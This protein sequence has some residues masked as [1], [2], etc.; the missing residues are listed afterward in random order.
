MNGSDPPATMQRQS[1]CFPKRGTQNVLHNGDP[2]FQQELTRLYSAPENTALEGLTT[3]KQALRTLPTDDFWAAA[4]E[5]M[6]KILGAEMTFIIKRVLVDDHDAAV[7]MPPLG[8]PGSCMLAAA[9]HYCGRDGTKDTLR[10]TKFHAWGC[11]CAYMRHDK[12]FLIP[13]G[14]PQFIPNNPNKVPTPAEAYIAIPLVAEGK[15]FAHFGAMWSEEGAAQRSL[16]WAFIEVLLHSLE[17]IILERF[18]EGSNFIKPAAAPRGDQ[19]VIPHDAVTLAQSLRP[20]APSLSHELRT[21][22][23]GVVGMLDVMYATVQDAVDTQTDPA[24]RQVFE[25]LKENIEVVQDSSR[26][27]VEAADNFVH[28][29]DMDLTIPEAPP[30]LP[31]D[32]SADAMSPFSANA[33][34]RRPEILVAGSV[35]PLSRPNKRRRDHAFPRPSITPSA[36]KIARVDTA[37]S[38]RPGASEKVADGC[39]QGDTAPKA[40]LPKPIVADLPTPADPHRAVEAADRSGRLIAPGLRHTSMREVF[41][42][43]INEGLKMGGRPDSATAQETD[44]GEIIEVRSRGS[45]GAARA[46]TI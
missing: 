36:S 28:A 43:V 16:S 13:E 17:D 15:P 30:L 29:A 31:Q 42:H 39:C 18:L 7:E 1:I 3:L 10:Q 46:K 11:P 33:A 37:D 23:Q 9:F 6:S 25:S 41:Q 19:R 22:M 26:R 12:V 32:D 40:A 4:T 27:A 21:P 35:L 20:Y 34:D 24:L 2:S 8:E 44:H 38:A 14:L 5:G 45:D